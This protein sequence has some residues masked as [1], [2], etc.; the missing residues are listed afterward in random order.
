[1]AKR[2]PLSLGIFSVTWPDVAGSLARGDRR[3]TPP[4][5]GVLVWSGADEQVRL[6][7]QHGVDGLLDGF[8]DQLAQF[9]FHGLLVE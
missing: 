7:V 1:M 3:G 2:M 6:L 8:P 4:L 5:F 9:V